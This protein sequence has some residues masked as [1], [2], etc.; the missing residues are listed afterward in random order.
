MKVISFA[1]WQALFISS[2]F[3][4]CACSPKA[5]DKIGFDL[6]GLSKEGL[7]DGVSLAYEFCIPNGDEYTQQVAAIDANV[8]FHS[9]GR[10]RIQCQKGQ[11]LCMSDTQQKNPKRVLR[12]LAKLPFVKEI[13][14]TF[15]E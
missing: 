1:W 6:E 13:Q 7:V 9:R 12:R 14:R 3:M 5:G 10:G 15:F 8:N 4:L 11:L 2:L